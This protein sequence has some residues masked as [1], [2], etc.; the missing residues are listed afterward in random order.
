MQM[1]LQS[2]PVKEN[3]SK[4]HYDVRLYNIYIFI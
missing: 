4:T 2:L 1:E 3:D